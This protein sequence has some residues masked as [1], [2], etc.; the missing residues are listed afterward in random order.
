MA[1]YCY[2]PLR[3]NQVRIIH[4]EDGDGDDTLRCRIE[5]VDVDSASYAAISYVWGEPSTECRMELSGADG[6]SEIPLTRDLSE[7]LRDL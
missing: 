3:A 5:H 1:Q 2:S 6:T 7:L 4:L